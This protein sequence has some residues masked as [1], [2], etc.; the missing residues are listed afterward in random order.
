MAPTPLHLA[1]FARVSL[2][3][4]FSGGSLLLVVILWISHRLVLH[5]CKR[6]P[7]G[8]GRSLLVA[9][10]NPL[11]VISTALVFLNVQASPSVPDMLFSPGPSALVYPVDQLNKTCA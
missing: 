8:L 10:I 3:G 11:K 4:S 5:D 6:T 9:T 7:A 1:P 2:T